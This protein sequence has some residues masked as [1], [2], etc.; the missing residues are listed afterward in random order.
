M[1]LNVLLICYN[2]SEFIEECVNSILMQKISSKRKNKIIE[3]IKQR[4]NI[5]EKIFGIK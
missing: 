5:F 3:I 2:Q 4:I 1:K